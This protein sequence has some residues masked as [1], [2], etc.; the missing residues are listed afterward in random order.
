MYLAENVF[1]VISVHV[2]HRVQH[3]LPDEQAVQCVIV[4]R[5]MT[6]KTSFK[7]ITNSAINEGTT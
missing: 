4:Q 7:K 5:L 1:H 3:K 6:C 2:Q